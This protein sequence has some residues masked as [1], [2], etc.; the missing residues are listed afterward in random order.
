MEFA[1]FIQEKIKDYKIISIIGLAKNVSK[2][3]TL[4]HII[5]ALKGFYMQKNKLPITLETPEHFLKEESFQKYYSAYKSKTQLY[6]KTN[7]R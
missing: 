5:Q 2:T 1:N 6:D 3:T 4:N 7:N